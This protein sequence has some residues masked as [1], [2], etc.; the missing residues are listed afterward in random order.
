M[1]TTTKIFIKIKRHIKIKSNKKKK[2]IHVLI[3]QLFFAFIMKAV[4]VYINV[5]VLSLHMHT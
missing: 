1:A 4:R 2:Y 5:Q 3:M